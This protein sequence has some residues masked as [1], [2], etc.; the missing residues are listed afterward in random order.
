MRL[1]TLLY[2]GD[3]Y[4]K[5]VDIYD[6]DFKRFVQERDPGDQYLIAYLLV[7]SAK[8]IIKEDIQALDMFLEIQKNLAEKASNEST[9]KILIENASY[10]IETILNRGS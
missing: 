10:N 6:A 4:K 2:Q 9:K 3:E 5:V 7:A 8:N 1:I